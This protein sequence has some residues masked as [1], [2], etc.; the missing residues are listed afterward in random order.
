MYRQI[1][2]KMRRAVRAE[3]VVMANHA[4]KEMKRDGLIFDDVVNAILTGEIINQQFD[5][6]RNEYK[7]VVYGDALNKDEIGLAFKPGY[8]DDI[9]IITV[10]RLRTDDYA[11]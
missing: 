6:E 1:L 9:V 8:N 2:D 5:P 4:V 11:S 10:Y 3:R 7:Y